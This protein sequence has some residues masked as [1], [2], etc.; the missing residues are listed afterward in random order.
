MKRGE[1]G[2]TLIEVMLVI[3]IT[4]IIM[5]PL[6]MT[7][8]TLLTNPQRSTDQNVV[9]HEVRNASHW[10]SRDVQMARNVTLDD[11]SGF[12]LSLDIPFND[13]PDND[14]SIDYL[15]DGSKL[16]RQEYDSLETLI[17]E[18]LIAD[19]ID[20]EDTTFSALGVSL[21]KLTIRASKDEAT[22]TRSYQVSQRLSSD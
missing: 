19:Y 10:I 18:T 15:F 3:G 21:Y 4:A 7:A 8:M 12:P 6:A 16:K 20:I 11:P 9:L 14:Y 1:K 17:S 22:V 2:F 5:G 13:N